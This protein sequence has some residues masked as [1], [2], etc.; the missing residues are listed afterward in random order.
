MPEPAWAEAGLRGEAAIRRHAGHALPHLKV[1]LGALEHVGHHRLAA[2]ELDA[3]EPV[4]VEAIVSEAV[5][6]EVE[7]PLAPHLAGE[8]HVAGI[9]LERVGHWIGGGRAGLLGEAVHV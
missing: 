7:R 9:G 2:H 8:G 3:A 5:V 6:V 1:A 4:G